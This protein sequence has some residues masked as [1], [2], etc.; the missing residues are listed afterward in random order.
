MAKFERFLF[1]CNL[2]LLQANVRYLRTSLA[3][4]TLCAT[5]AAK[6]TVVKENSSAHTN[7]TFLA[8]TA[9]HSTKNIRHLAQRLCATL[10]SPQDTATQFYRQV[11]IRA[12]NARN[13]TIQQHALL[14][15][16]W[17]LQARAEGCRKHVGSFTDG[18]PVQRIPRTRCTSAPVERATTCVGLVSVACVTTCGNSGICLVCWNWRHSLQWSHLCTHTHVLV[19][20]ILRI[21]MRVFA[22]AHARRSLAHKKNKVK[23][24]R[25]AVRCVCASEARAPQVRQSLLRK[26]NN[27]SS[28]QVFTHKQQPVACP[29]RK[30][31]EVK[32]KIISRVNYLFNNS[33]SVNYLSMLRHLKLKQQAQA[34]LNLTTNTNS[35]ISS[36]VSPIDTDQ[37]HWYQRSDSTRSWN[38]DTDENE[39]TIANQASVAE[40]LW[41]LQQQRYQQHQLAHQQYQLQPPAPPSSPL[42]YSTL[43]MQQMSEQITERKLKLAHASNTLNNVNLNA[44][45]LTTTTTQA[46][47]NSINKSRR[48]YDNTDSI[49]LKTNNNKAT[50]KTKTLN[51]VTATATIKESKQKQ[52][53]RQ[54]R[55]S[56]PLMEKKRRARI[57]ECLDTLK[58]YVLQDSSTNFQALGVD[59][60]SA[61]EDSLARLILHSSGL[62]NR[63]GGRKNASK[64][65]KAD[66]LELTVDYVRRLHERQKC[67][68][69]FE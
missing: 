41:L 34:A 67:C 9:K 20:Q 13:L 48:A 56:K 52:R 4:C 33:S 32:V 46:T 1:A 30:R 5:S 24:E 27:K 10:W 36:S 61:D 2:Q 65:E 39:A 43:I 8:R 23:F 53:Q 63:H 44:L 28:L 16:L 58:A 22:S 51:S 47:S 7:R 17:S 62:I 38:A 45:T 57:N 29:T 12:K 31:E 18:Q 66:I 25:F 49:K 59:A 19:L 64:L 3:E 6:L 11:T 42:D 55:A 15:R 26:N 14:A 50:S 60:D 54:R 40:Q 21:V 35:S 37:C 69:W 68:C